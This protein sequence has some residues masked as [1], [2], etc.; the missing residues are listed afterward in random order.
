MFATY[1]LQFPSPI[2]PY[3]VYKT[4]KNV[5]LCWLYC[6]YLMIQCPW[7]LYCN[8]KYFSLEIFVV[9]VVFTNDKE[10]LLGSGWS[11][12]SR[13]LDTATMLWNENGEVAVLPS[14]SNGHILSEIGRIV[15]R[16][17]TNQIKFIRAV[18]FNEFEFGDN[19]CSRVSFWPLEYSLSNH[20]DIYAITSMNDIMETIVV[21]TFGNNIC[22]VDKWW[23]VMILLVYR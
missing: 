6:K 17:K 20:G 2:T 5:I 8:G 7:Q 12:I 21:A 22:V 3:T 14:T 1:C 15:L 11:G 18:V 23:Q 13:G 19:I 10:T 4:S 9:F 16:A